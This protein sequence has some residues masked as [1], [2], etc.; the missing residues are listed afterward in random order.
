MKFRNPIAFRPVPVTSLCT[1]IYLALVVPLLLVNHVV[2]SPSQADRGNLTEAWQDLQILTKDFHPYNSHPNDD[3]RAWLLRRIE[4]LIPSP[5]KSN[6]T[7]KNG[8]PVTVFSDTSSNISFSGTQPGLSVYFEGSNIIVYVRGSQDDPADWWLSSDQPTGKG[9]VLV[10]AHFDSVSTAYG[11]TDDGVGVVTILQLIKHFSHHQPLKGLVALFNNGEEDYLNGAR[12]FSQHPLS[13]F[14][15]TFLNLEGAG[16]GGRAILFRTTDTEVTKAYQA[17]RLPFGNVVSADAFKRGVIRS[18]TDYSFFNGALGMRGLDV[19]FYE[20][21][22]RYHTAADNTKHTSKASLNHMMSTAFATIK[23]LTSDQSSEFEPSE[24]DKANKYP[25]GR[26]SD[27]VWFD[28]LGTTFAVFALDTLFAISVALLA[29]GPLTIIGILVSLYKVDK[30]YIFSYSRQSRWSEP[31]E[32]VGLKGLRGLT[33]WP[34]SFILASAAIVGLAFLLTIINPFIIYS[35]PYAVWSMMMSAWL[36]VAYVCV[37]FSDFIRPTAL[38]R[39]YALLWMFA[40]AWVVLVLATKAERQQRIASGY[41]L[42]F[43]FACIFLATSI[44]LLEMFRLPRTSDYADDLLGPP[45]A[46]SNAEHEGV[47]S[48]HP[49]PHPAPSETERTEPGEEQQQAEEDH[50]TADETTSLLHGTG[51]TTFKRYSSP[52]RRTE[53]ATPAEPSTGERKKRRKVYGSEQPW[54]GTLPSSLWLLEFLLV[55]VVPVIFIGQVSLIFTSATYQTLA[56]GNSPLT[57]YIGLAI[58]VVLLLA[59]IGPFLHRFTYEIPT[60]LF[61]VLIGTLLYNIF[62]F[63]FS[64]NNKLKLYFI[65]RVD[66]DT[67][68]NNVSLTGIGQSSYL[69]DTITSLPSS[70]GQTPKCHPSQIRHD[71]AECSWS[72]L[73]PKVVSDPDLR[74]SDWVSFQINRVPTNYTNTRSTGA[75]V[76]IKSVQAHFRITGDNT[77]ACKI[78]FSQPIRDFHVK[79]SGSDPRFPRVGEAGSTELRLWSRAWNHTWEVDVWWNRNDSLSAQQ[80]IDTEASREH[81]INGPS[82]SP[83]P[84]FD[85]RIVC[86][87]S[88]DNQVGVIP[89]LDEVKHFAPAWVTVTKAS[90]GLV[91]GSKAFSV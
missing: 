22:S 79:D 40:A 39:A 86:L 15:R 68:A 71:L 43:N 77:R 78:L 88:D 14:P 53:E 60:F 69:L 26:G 67:G 52:H 47:S 6:H 63:P 72:G 44:S 48:P 57:L 12:A 32:S 80:A 29:V 23:E 87:W 90:D 75:N 9:G 30:L 89:A 13:H 36:V 4:D 50:Q 34:I 55:A 46:Q 20:P 49:N 11:A 25:S 35:S 18:E 59:P 2:P 83:S 5:S 74:Y 19:A 61:L 85:G 64:P 7:S 56:D 84:L 27:G 1:I 21:R 31:S 3:V 76:A 82:G 62:A 65:Q 33:R 81:H 42:V 41:I 24:D 16:A 10:N 37:A 38:Q 91:E 66:L 17:S 58:L 70:V 54:S 45:A 8:A 51:R 28:I 73:G